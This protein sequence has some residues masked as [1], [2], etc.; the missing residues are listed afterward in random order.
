MPSLTHI[1]DRHV[2]LPLHLHADAQEHGD[3][4]GVLADRPMPQRAHARIDQD[5]RDGIARRRVFLALVGLV[6][7]ANEIER[8]VIGNVLQGVGD[9]VDQVVLFNDGHG[10]GAGD[11][12]A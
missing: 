9:A 7:G 8:M 1:G 6:H 12:S 5:L 4:A 11:G 3:D 2:G 10:Y